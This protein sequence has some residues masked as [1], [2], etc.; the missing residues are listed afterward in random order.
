MSS[1]KHSSIRVMLADDHA[2]VRN[3]VA[4]ILAEQSDIEV[5]AEAQDGEA[6]V[7]LF[8]KERPDVSL[9]DLRMPI[10]DG[11][12]VV[13][14]IRREFLTPCSSSSPR[15][16]DDDVDRAL[17]LVRKH[18]LAERCLPRRISL[19]ACAP[20]ICDVGIARCSV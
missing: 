11:A 6:A 17:W 15:S 5:I 9:V 14:R 19:P 7:E 20:C 3:G 8:R 13:E 4:Q 16:T 1:V 12:E 18:V 10:V 2:I